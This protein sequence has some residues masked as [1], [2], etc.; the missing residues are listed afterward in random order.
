MKIKKN[1][2]IKIISGK[3][4]NKIGKVIKVIPDKN[5]VL[6]EG[7]NLYKKHVRPKREGEKGQTVLVS[8]P[9]NIS[10]IMVIC[11]S[12]GKAVKIGYSVKNAIKTRI[13]KKCG[14][15]I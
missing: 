6:I 8:R 9:L 10:N 13:C 12:C 14:M 4:R 3:D 11:Q 7:L 2:T 5:K 15:K 1:D